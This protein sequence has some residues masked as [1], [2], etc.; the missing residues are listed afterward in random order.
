[1]SRCTRPHSVQPTAVSLIRLDPR[2]QGG[3]AAANA[4]TPSPRQQHTHGLTVLQCAR[5]GA[6]VDPHV[7]RDW[8]IFE[9]RLKQNY[10]RLQK[11]KRSYLAQIVGFGILVVYFAWFGFVSTQSYKF[12][13]KLLSGGSAY[14]IYHIQSIKYSAQCNRV[15]HQFR[16]RFEASP[17]V[18]TSMTNTAD[19]QPAKQ[20]AVPRQL[21][22]G[23]WDFRTTYYRKR[24]AAKRRQQERAKRDRQRKNSSGMSSFRTSERRPKRRSHHREASH[25]GGKVSAGSPPSSMASE[26]T[27]GGAFWPGIDSATD[28]GS[29]TSSSHLDNSESEAQDDIVT[30]QPVGYASSNSTPTPAHSTVFWSRSMDR[31][32]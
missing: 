25:V 27:D 30:P 6:P 16:M 28:D 4:S 19:Q 17:L 32:N 23:Y 12:T 8:L 11:K 20:T 15:M 2:R 31:N 9:E 22:D 14:C 5:T 24:D 7:Y 3:T 13:C 29:T 10:R 21:R 26:G 1:M 18:R